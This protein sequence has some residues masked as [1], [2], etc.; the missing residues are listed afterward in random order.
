[1][2][3]HNAEASAFFSDLRTMNK[4]WAKEFE[5]RDGITNIKGKEF[6]ISLS[7]NTSPELSQYWRKVAATPMTTDSQNYLEAR[8]MRATI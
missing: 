7:A 1:M 4:K 2:E 8:R 5:N 6:G 3:Q